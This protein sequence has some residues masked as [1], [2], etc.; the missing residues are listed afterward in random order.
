LKRE[1]FSCILKSSLSAWLIMMCTYTAV[2]QKEEDAFV[3]LEV[4]I[5]GG[6]LS[7]FNFNS[8]G[9]GVAGSIQPR[10]FL[11]PKLAITA[12]AQMGTYV[13]IPFDYPEYEG[14]LNTFSA[15]AGIHSRDR[16]Q[17]FSM[18]WGI[19]SGVAFTREYLGID[20]NGFNQYGSSRA[21]WALQPSFGFAASRFELEAM[22]HYSPSTF[23]R[24]FTL[25]IGVRIGGGRKD[26]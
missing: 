22:Y 26:R 10:I 7:K 14:D 18:L 12:R 24:Y 25:N 8:F 2:A 3:P 23:A 21:Y 20:A 16:N 1:L 15:L 13:S 6:F 17:R 9:F 4:K 5:G 19:E 11:A